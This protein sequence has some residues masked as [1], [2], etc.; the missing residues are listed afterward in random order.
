LNV[1]SNQW[2]AGAYLV[3]PRR[4]KGIRIERRTKLTDASFGVTTAASAPPPT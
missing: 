4:E 2:V 3:Q 1:A